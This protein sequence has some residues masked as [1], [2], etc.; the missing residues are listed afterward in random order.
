VGWPKTQIFE[1]ISFFTMFAKWVTRSRPKNS[2]SAGFWPVFISFSAGR[3]ESA[4][5]VCA[6]SNCKTTTLTVTTLNTSDRNL[7]LH[8]GRVLITVPMWILRLFATCLYL[9]LCLCLFSLAVFA[10][11]TEEQHQVQSPAQT[12]NGHEDHNGTYITRGLLQK[13]SEMVDWK[14]QHIEFEA[15]ACL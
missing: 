15:Y 5:S 4:L 10:A 11:L 1:N 14:T 3:R 12:I 9:C 8:N 2:K 13:M 7:L 6:T